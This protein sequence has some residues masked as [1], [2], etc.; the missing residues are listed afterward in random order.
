MVKKSILALAMIAVISVLGLTGCGTTG[1]GSDKILQNSVENEDNSDSAENSAEENL[2]EIDW[3]AMAGEVTFPTEYM[4][5]YDVAC[6]DGSIITIA[7]G[8][9]LAGNIYYKDAE[10][11][12]VFVKSG[13]NYNLY[14]KD[15]SGTFTEERNTKYRDEYIDKATKEFLECAKQNSVMAA[16]SAKNEGNITIAE[17]NCNYY[18]IRVGFANFV[19]SY[20]YAFDEETGIC[21]AKT[22]QKEISGHIQEGD[23]GFTCIEFQTSNVKFDLPN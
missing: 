19:Q 7:R 16:S 1:Q 9:D 12:E 15:E 23:S 6:E 3:E 4:I 20:E 2:E 17:R 18:S 22:E 11:E 21:L 8:R 13:M 14:T 5:S 10:V